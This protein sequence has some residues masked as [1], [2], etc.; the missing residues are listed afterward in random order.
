MYFVSYFHFFFIFFQFF[1][2]FSLFW[3]L[4]EIRCISHYLGDKEL[5]L[6][7]DTVNKAIKLFAESEEGYFSFFLVSLSFFL[8]F[9]LSRY[10]LPNFSP[11]VKN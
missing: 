7:M 11:Q 1:D 8:S 2:F 4:D 10:L 6:N 3:V 9:F 5:K